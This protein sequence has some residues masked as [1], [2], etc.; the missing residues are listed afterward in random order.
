MDCIG[1]VLVALDAAGCPAPEV[2][3]YGTGSVRFVLAD[4]LAGMFRAIPR[5]AAQ[6]GDVLVFNDGHYPCHLGIC[7]EMDGV[8]TVI[9]ARMNRRMVVEEPVA[10]EVARALVAAY[11]LPVEA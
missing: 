6:P 8:Q 9:H 7:A 2:P 11:A 4:S 5:T 10:H 1:V 3:P